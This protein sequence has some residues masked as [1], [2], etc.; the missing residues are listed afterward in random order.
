MATVQL[1]ALQDIEAAQ[2]SLRLSQYGGRMSNQFVDEVKGA[3]LFQFNWGELLGAAPT[4]ISMM[5]AC[6]VAASNEEAKKIS[7]KDSMPTNGF[8]YLINRPDPTLRA[9]LLDGWYS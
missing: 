1:S 8:Q 6:Y 4:A 2:K 9:S 5:C 3:A 7:L